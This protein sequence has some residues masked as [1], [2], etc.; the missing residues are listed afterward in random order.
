LA[1][2]WAAT[3]ACHRPAPP[4]PAQSPAPAP[5][6]KAAVKTVTLFFVHPETGDLAPALSTLTPSDD[7]AE[8][9]RQVVAQ[10][11]AGPKD[12][13]LISP[14]P[15]GTTLRAVYLI[16]PTFVVDFGL[17]A[18]APAVEGS[19]NELAF[20][21]AVTNTVCLNFSDIKNVRILVNDTDDSP[22]L[23]HLSLRAAFTPKIQ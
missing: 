12:P 18:E 8:Q 9:A 22:L 13:S 4:A 1:A 17:P 7:L 19:R 20:A 10:L 3:L 2:F 16:G 6:P 15:E 21:Y 14:I 11:L 5:E 23:T